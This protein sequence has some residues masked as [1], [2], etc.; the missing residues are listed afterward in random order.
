MSENIIIALITVS[1]SLLGSLIGA[2]ATLKAAGIKIQRPPLQ[3]IKEIKK[4]K[5]DEGLEKPHWAWGV[6]GGAIIGAIITIAILVVMGII[7]PSTS[8]STPTTSDFVYDDFD[9]LSYNDSFNKSLWISTNELTQF[10]KSN[11]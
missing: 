2:Y 9:N 3:T 4:Q 5:T 11:T 6:L 10:Y 1:G 8:T 7:P